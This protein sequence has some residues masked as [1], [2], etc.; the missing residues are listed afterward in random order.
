MMNPI[1][2]LIYTV[3]DIYEWVVIAAVIVAMA[4]R[5]RWESMDPAG[6]PTVAAV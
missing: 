5:L 3:L 4:I 2:Y 1:A 6:R